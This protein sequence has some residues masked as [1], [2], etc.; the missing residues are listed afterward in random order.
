MGRGLLDERFK[1]IEG[2]RKSHYGQRFSILAQWSHNL[3]SLNLLHFKEEFKSTFS[4][5][6]WC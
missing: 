1:R 5:F 2:Q 4:R 6:C 3:H